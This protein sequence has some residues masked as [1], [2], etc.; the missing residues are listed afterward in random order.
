[1]S[2]SHLLTLI[3]FAFRY[4]WEGGA[5]WGGM[6]D[7]WAYTNDKS[8]VATVQQALLA[9]VGPDNNYMPPAYEASLGNDDQAFWAFAVLSAVEYQFPVPD[10]NVSTVWLDLAE[11]VFNTQWPRWDNTSCAGGLKWQIFDFNA[12]YDYKN[13]VSNGGF[14]QIAAR[15]ARYTS[16]QTYVQWAEKAWDWMEDVGLIDADYNVYD[17]TNDLLNCTQVDHLLWSYNP[18]MLLYG[19]AMLYNSTNGSQL[20]EDRTNGLLTS[21]ANTFFSPYSNATNM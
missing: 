1:M 8:Y 9:Q 11:A 4:W 5:I 15:L 19:T 12:G 10:G 14:F 7:Y 20:W 2:L 13:S 17:G 6:I 3:L 21:C 18:S 16:N